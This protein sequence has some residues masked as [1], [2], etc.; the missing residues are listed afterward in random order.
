MLREQGAIIR[1]VDESAWSNCLLNV[2]LDKGPS[3]KEA[4]EMFTLPASVSLWF[5]DDSHYEIENGL[6]CNECKHSLSWPR[7]EQK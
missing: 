4:S 1:H 5:N 7:A 6:A 3:F 2:A